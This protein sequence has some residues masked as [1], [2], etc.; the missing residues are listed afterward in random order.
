[1]SHEPDAVHRAYAKQALVEISSLDKY[2]PEA[3][4]KV[5]RELELWAFQFVLLAAQPKIKIAGLPKFILRDM[6]SAS[7][8]CY[9]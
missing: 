2:E 4:A 8:P 6:A 3:A 5:G 7:Q 1:M 9:K